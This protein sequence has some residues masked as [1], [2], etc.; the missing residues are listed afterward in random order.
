LENNQST[1]QQE[2][3]SLGVHFRLLANVIL[4][5]KLSSFVTEYDSDNYN[6]HEVINGTLLEN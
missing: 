6:F 5:P 4:R 3:N 2:D 1:I